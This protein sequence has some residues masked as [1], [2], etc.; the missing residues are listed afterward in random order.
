MDGKELKRSEKT[1]IHHE[2]SERIN[3]EGYERKRCLPFK[4]VLH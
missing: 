1:E 3:E 2:V 4:Y